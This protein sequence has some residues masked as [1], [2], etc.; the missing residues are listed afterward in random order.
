[1]AKPLTI[2][3]VRHGEKPG[4]PN[5]DGD[6]G[7]NLSP[8][9]YVRAAAIG[10]L[11]PTAFATPDF[12]FATAASASSNRP[13]ETVTP[14][15]DALG[16]EV[17]SPYKDKDYAQ[18]AQELMCG[19]YDQKLVLIGWH[20]GKIPNLAASLGVANPP[21]PWPPDVFD[22]VWRIDYDAAGNATLTNLPQCFLYGDS[23]S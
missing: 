12:I 20:H 22:R 8:R 2:F 18:L 10:E 3:I 15:A 13:A 4:D 11:F 17:L 7:P 21:S 6:G 9:G 14:L 5:D 19:S 1:M 16:I 23:D